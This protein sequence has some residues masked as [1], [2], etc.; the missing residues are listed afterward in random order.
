MKSEYNL[1]KLSKRKNP[2]LKDVK[3][4]DQ[5]LNKKYGKKGTAK[6]INFDEKSTN[7]MIGEMIK[8]ERKKAHL[9]QEEIAM[10]IGTK[11]SYFVISSAMV[12]K[13]EMK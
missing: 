5:L 6:R 7:F 12:A 1:S 3:S 8:A 11:K 4:L 10:K 2:Y 9:T 13:S